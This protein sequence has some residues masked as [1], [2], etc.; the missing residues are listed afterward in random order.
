MPQGSDTGANIV[1]GGAFP[2]YSYPLS[3]HGGVRREGRI[4]L[5][6]R[7]PQL[8]QPIQTSQRDEPWQL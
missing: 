2:H 8:A 7:H 5:R 1:F 4:K 3:A 6:L